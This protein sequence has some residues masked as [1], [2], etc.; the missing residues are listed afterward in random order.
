M[1]FRGE[2]M[3]TSDKTGTAKDEGGWSTRYTLLRRLATRHTSDAW[4]EFLTHYRPYVLMVAKAMQLPHNEAEDVT[5]DVMVKLWQQLPDK[6]S[7]VEGKRF[8]SWLSTVIRNQVHN[9][10]RKPE[11][12]RELV[13][14]PENV[15]RMDATPLSS[16]PEIEEIAEREWHTYI[17]TLAW[18]RAQPH[19]TE[20]ECAV[21]LL[22][23]QGR[24]PADIA[25]QVAIGRNSVYVYYQRAKDL[26]REEIRLIRRELGW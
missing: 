13:V 12:R 6:Y 19:L 9:Y 15:G 10:R 7:Q 20:K 1:V 4:E 17:A 11:V 24:S 3:L 26:L 2:V 18:R 23:N 5:Q 21:F 25:R 22:R 8:R 14:E 16:P